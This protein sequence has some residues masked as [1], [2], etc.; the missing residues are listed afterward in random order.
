[1]AN[2]KVAETDRDILVAQYEKAIQGAF[3][4]VSDALAQR[5]T[6]GEQLAATQSL[7]DAAAATRRLS[8]ARYEKGVDS[9]LSVLDAQRTLYAAQQNLI[10]VRLARLANRVTLYKSLGGGA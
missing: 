5:G 2:L 1:M 10:A 9:Y 4:E 3:R 8:D 7:V 6:L